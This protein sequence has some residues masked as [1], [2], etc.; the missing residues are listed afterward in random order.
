V[1][2]PVQGLLYEQGRLPVQMREHR[3]VAAAGERHVQDAVLARRATGHLLRL[4]VV[5]RELGSVEHAHPASFRAGSRSNSTLRLIRATTSAIPSP[6]R[7]FVKTNGL[8]RR[9]SL[10]SAS[11]TS[12]LAWT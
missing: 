9:I 5:E 7:Q 4:I 3:P 11:I 12:R 6:V 8:S 2:V 10:E 1:L